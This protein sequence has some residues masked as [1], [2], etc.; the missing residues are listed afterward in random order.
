MQ[1][2]DKA[3]A[4]IDAEDQCQK[5]CHCTGYASV[6]FGLRLAFLILSAVECTSTPLC[7]ASS[8]IHLFLKSFSEA[9]NVAGLESYNKNG[10]QALAGAL[11]DSL[12]TGAEGTDFAVTIGMKSENAIMMRQLILL[13][14]ASRAGAMRVD[15]ANC[16]RTFGQRC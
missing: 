9:E 3:I 12:E 2:S 11:A 7:Q 8:A 16:C 6:H 1:G 15:S 13:A 14:S 10:I 4:H 5:R